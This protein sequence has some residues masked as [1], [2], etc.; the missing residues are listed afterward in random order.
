MSIHDMM[1]LPGWNGTKKDI[2]NTL[3]CINKKFKDSLISFNN[4]N[5]PVSPFTRL[6]AQRQFS[7][8]GT[9]GTIKAKNSPDCPETHELDHPVHWDELYGNVRVG[10]VSVISH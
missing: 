5:V 9:Q 4:W 3:I 6:Q 7:Y 10:R 1:V 8:G 2:S